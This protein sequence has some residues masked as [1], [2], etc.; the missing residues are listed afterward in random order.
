MEILSDVSASSALVRA[1]IE[2][3]N[4][5]V[6]SS[7][8]K[9]CQFKVANTIIPPVSL[10]EREIEGG[11][12]DFPR[13]RRKQQPMKTILPPSA[14]NLNSAFLADKITSLQKRDLVVQWHFPNMEESQMRHG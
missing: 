14:C 9:D 1:A 7:I 13:R 11:R 2:D 8:H 4:A 12:D 5:F 6:S 3:E 10:T